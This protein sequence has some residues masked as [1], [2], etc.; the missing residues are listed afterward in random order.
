MTRMAGSEYDINKLVSILG[1][2]SPE[3]LWEFPDKTLGH[4]S[5]NPN[6]GRFMDVPQDKDTVRRLYNEG[7]RK[8]KVGR[9]VLENMRLLKEYLNLPRV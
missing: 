6:P 8:S 2:G 7:M 4:I 1:Q 3:M 9:S 5:Q